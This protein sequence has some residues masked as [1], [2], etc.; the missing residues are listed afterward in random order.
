MTHFKNNLRRARRAIGAIVGMDVYAR[1]QLRRPK[2]YL[3]NDNASWCVCPAGLTDRSIVYSFG[4]GEDISFDLTLIQQFGMRVHAFDPTPRSAVWM[5]MQK[6]P[7]EFVFHEYGIGPFDGSVVFYPPRNAD[8]VS[9]SIVARNG[10]SSAT[11]EAPV[12]RLRTIMDLLGHERVD[13][14]KMDIEG[15]EYGVISDLISSGVEARQLLVEFHHRWRE[16]GVLRTKKAIYDLKNAGFRI[17][18]VSP[19]GTEFSFVRGE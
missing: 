17:F 16:V 15:A 3:G 10:G 18:D 14:L 11:V 6:T 1:V 19:A 13:L 5:R 9:Y 7:K 4:V 8:F 12:Y 2:I